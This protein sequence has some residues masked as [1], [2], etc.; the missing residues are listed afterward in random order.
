[1]TVRFCGFTDDGLLNS[2]VEFNFY[3]IISL[4]PEGLGLKGGGGGAFT[5]TREMREAS[6]RIPPVDSGL[7]C[8]NCVVL[9]TPPQDRCASAVDAA[10]IAHGAI[11]LWDLQE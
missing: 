5:P 1:M 9:F 10:E 2:S 8:R 3:C 4:Q 7:V 11:L 6:A